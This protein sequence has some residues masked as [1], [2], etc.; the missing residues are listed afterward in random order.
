[1]ISFSVNDSTLPGESGTEE[2][3]GL[4]SMGLIGE[5]TQLK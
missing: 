1:M 3:D 5:S 4:P 2:A